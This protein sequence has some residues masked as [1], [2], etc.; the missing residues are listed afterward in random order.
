MQIESIQNLFIKEYQSQ[1]KERKLTDNNK[2]NFSK[3]IDIQLSQKG[4]ALSE[5]QLVIK[6]AFQ[7]IH[8]IEEIDSAKLD[9][10]KEK[11]KSGFYDS[12]KVHQRLG[13][14]LSNLLSST[15]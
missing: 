9:S 2:E 13:E 4:K 6:N 12:E 15:M 14:K 1:K 3:E 5:K 10:I 7:S 8:G 11:I